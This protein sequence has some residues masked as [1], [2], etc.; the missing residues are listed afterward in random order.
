MLG[1]LS[2][3]VVRFLEQILST[4]SFPGLFSLKLGGAGKDLD[5]LG[6]VE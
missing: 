1:Y 6:P 4:T 5:K 2:L 3:E